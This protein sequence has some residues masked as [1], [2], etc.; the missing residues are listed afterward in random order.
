MKLND[1][2]LGVQLFIGFSIILVLFGFVA[3]MGYKGLAQ[4]VDRSDKSSDMQQIVISILEAR[5]QEKNLII[6]GDAEYR[7]KTLKAIDEARKQAQA[8]KAIFSKP[9]NKQLM[10]DAV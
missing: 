7:V 5:R 2:K 10:D 9:E 6:R 8:D 3:T 1:M 4:V